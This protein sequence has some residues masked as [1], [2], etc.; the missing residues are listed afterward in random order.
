MHGIKTI[1]FGWGS[2]V[3]HFIC[4]GLWQK[5]SLEDRDWSIP[6]LTVQIQQKKK[7]CTYMVRL[8]STYPLPSE[9]P[10]HGLTVI[11][12]VS[13]WGHLLGESPLLVWS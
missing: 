2:A 13:V 3:F 9:E 11:A 8:V 5:I 4:W 10:I 12:D 7:H 6:S 1:A